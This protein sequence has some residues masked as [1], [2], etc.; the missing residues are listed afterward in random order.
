LINPLRL[1]WTMAGKR[2][3]RSTPSG[4]FC[5]FALFLFSRFAIVPMW[6]QAHEFMVMGIHPHALIVLDTSRDE[7]VAEIPLRGRAPKEI[8]HSRDGRH[9]YVTT[10]GRSQIEVV[11]FVHRKVEEVI[12]P[13]PPGYKFVIYGTALS[14]DD[15]VLYLHV[16]PV[17][18]LPDEYRAESPQILACNLSTRKSRKIAEVPE[19][20]GALVA[21][22]DGKR[23]MGWGRDLYFVDVAQGRVTKTFPLETPAP[24]HGP[25]DS[26]PLFVQ[27]DQTG[28]FSVPYYTTNPANGNN[29]MGLVNVDVETGKTDLVELGPAVPLF[30]SVVSPDLKRAYAVMNKMVAV[31]LEARRVTSVLDLDRTKYVINISRDGRKL[32]V[33]GAG[34]FMDIYDAATLKQIKK[35][36]LS[37][38]GSVTSLRVVPQGAVPDER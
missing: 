7:V 8:E 27:Y 18:I 30:S 16:K 20:V 4:W 5:L 2:P 26:L 1:G 12:Q 14:R 31:D 3:A 23:L 11:D 15:K 32:Y 28:I 22:G 25:L 9:L 10:E 37:G 35:I 34:P 6:A 24:D 17:R 29:V 38:D 13:A 21:L 36:E 33:S 19:G